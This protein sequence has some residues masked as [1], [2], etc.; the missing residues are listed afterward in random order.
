MRWRIPKIVVS[1]VAAVVSL[2]LA[3]QFYSNGASPAGI[4]W[5]SLKGQNVRVIAPDF[6]EGE[7]RRV[8]FMMDSLSGSICYGLGQQLRPLG[9]PVVLHAN[10]AA[11][12]HDTANYRLT[13]CNDFTAKH[14]ER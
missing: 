11:Y 13:S 4:R 9:S 14:T 5:Q 7:A 6:A 10:N 8:L 3:A 1:L 12:L 2:P